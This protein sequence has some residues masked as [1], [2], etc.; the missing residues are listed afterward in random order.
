MNPQ[1]QVRASDQ[2]RPALR[3]R[4]Q[5][6]AT[7]A[8]VIDRARSGRS[9]ALVVAG[10]AGVGK[11]ALLRAAVAP[12][13]ARTVRVERIV[14]AESEMELPYAGVHQLCGRMMGLAVQLPEPQ[15]DALEAALGLRSGAPPSPFLVGLSLLGLLSEAAAERPLVCVV[16][17][18]HWLDE[19]SRRALAF[20][21][22]R[23]DAEG[24]ALL[25]GTRR[26][27][28]EFAGLERLTV[29]GL[30]DEAARELF[31]LAVPGTI[32]RRVRDQLIAEARG[33][34]LA[35][36]ELPR[37]LSPA[38]MAGG[39]ALVGSLPLES[40]IEESV[41]AQLAP[42]PAEAR[43]VLLLASADPTGDPAL[44]WR[45]IAVLGLDAG[46]LDAAERSGALEV[47]TRIGFRHPIVRS[48]VYRAGAP[49]D[50]RR[51]HA[52]LAEATYAERDPDRRAWHRASATVRPDEAVAHALE[53][54]ADRARTRGGVAAVALFLERSAELTPARGRRAQRLIAAA[55]AKHDAG[56]PEP[57]LRLLDTADDLTLT[58]LQQ[59]LAARLRAQARY[60]LRRDHGALG[61]LLAA[62]RR[63]ESLH[64]VLARDT[65]L[66]ALA[67]ALYSSRLGHEEDVP[68]VARAILDVT[69]DDHSHRARDLILRGQAL[70]ALEG[71]SAAVETLRAALAA[72]EH[73]TPDQLELRWMWLGCRAAVD[74]WDADALRALADRQATI[75]RE[76]GVLA[77][78]PITLCFVM[79]VR[80]M[81]GDLDGFSHACDEV[82]LIKS[83][84]GHLLPRFGR[85]ILE[86]F[87]GRDEALARRV[88]PLRRDAERRGEGNALSVANY[89]EAVAANGAGRYADAVAAARQELPH[90]REYS[91][92]MRTLPEL[93]EAA[94][95]TDD[96]ELAEQ[97]L[98]QL[99][100]V[101]RPAGGDWALGVLAMTEAQLASGTEAE[102]RYEDAIERFARARM[103]LMEGRTRL[104]YGEALR[105]QARRIDARV[106]LRA[107]HRLLSQ[108][109]AE[110]FA[111]R[112]ARE[113]AATGET[114]RPRLAEATDA[115]TEQ[116]LNVAR[117]AR[118]GLTNRDIGSRLFISSRTAEYHLRKVFLKLGLSS[119]AELKQALT[120]PA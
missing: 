91:F 63:L 95:R 79:S 110:A 42:L 109:G 37:A 11:T 83:A 99:A 84:T 96:R 16:D 73:Q 41:L 68:T 2:E 120:E 60:A 19:V 77:I 88:G 30:A 10:E 54:S 97:G 6:L 98:A 72:F 69:A 20:V 89:A 105:R 118:E 17:D 22:R 58:P 3:G 55:Q 34:P 111:E 78:L 45:A 56:A 49:A 102:A 31:R 67:A 94:V 92:A 5:E 35:L 107:A 104:L 32:D 38:Q 103:P 24:I 59:A 106:E 48:A 28:D 23:L 64:P 26:V 112:A 40:R 65:Y 116:E 1:L 117:L 36:Q 100:A 4:E 57:A 44:L 61:E 51:V 114:M 62:A 80:L 13:D 81:D 108:C 86:A 25:L 66:E 82:D 15:R 14:A 87:R 21:A 27:P 101:T 52:A 70:L 39:F 47:G 29:G 33:N 9:G 43:M 53:E 8:T 75:A 76:Q 50:R 119:R 93:V 115:L 74:L 7:L 46:A 12:L 71:Q 85:V 113:L 90:A 18:A